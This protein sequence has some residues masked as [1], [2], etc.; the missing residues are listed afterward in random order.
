MTKIAY[1]SYFKSFI[2]CAFYYSDE[3]WFFCLCD[4]R[5]KAKKNSFARAR[6][7]YKSFDWKEIDK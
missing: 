3:N 5:G 1:S 6:S 7:S 2:K 4:E